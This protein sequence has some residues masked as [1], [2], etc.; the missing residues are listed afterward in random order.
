LGADETAGAK[1]QSR[2]DTD[3]GA[4]IAHLGSAVTIEVSDI[5]I[6]HREVCREN[7]RLTN[8]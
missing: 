7:R 2:R 8:P 4:I 3:N 1:S 5:P 6:R